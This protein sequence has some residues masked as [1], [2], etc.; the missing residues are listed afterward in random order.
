[1]IALPSIV[2]LFGS[3]L[4]MLD[5]FLGDLDNKPRKSKKDLLIELVEIVTELKK[6]SNGQSKDDFIAEVLTEMKRTQGLSTK[7]FEDLLKNKVGY[8]HRNQT[9]YTQ[10]DFDAVAINI[11]IILN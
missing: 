5:F 9:Q 1:M 3:K 10:D 7:K 11:G 2:L 4:D 6:R 8:H